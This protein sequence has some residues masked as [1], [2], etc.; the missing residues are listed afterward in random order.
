M[1]ARVIPSTS[2]PDGA[3]VIT[4]LSLPARWRAALIHGNHA[5]L[6]REDLFVIATVQEL[7]GF[8]SGALTGKAVYRND[9]DAIAEGI[10]PTECLVYEFVDHEHNEQRNAAREG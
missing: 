4:K 7:F 9:H 5:D 2:L 8:C 6:S 1:E 3:T 10:A